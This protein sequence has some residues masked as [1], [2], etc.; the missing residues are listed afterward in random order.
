MDE[1]KIVVKIDENGD[2]NAETF[3]FDGQACVDELSKL[4]K[5]LAVVTAE[6]KKSEY[7]KSKTIAQTK[8]T[9]KI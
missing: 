1:Q 4:M 2:M 3:G 9:N 7:F 8:V 6:R 5:N